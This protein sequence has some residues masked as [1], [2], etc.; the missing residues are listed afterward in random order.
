MQILKNVIRDYVK[1]HILLLLA[2]LLLSMAI[3]VLSS[4]LP[5]VLGVLVNVITQEI[6]TS[7]EIKVTPTFIILVYILSSIGIAIA[8]YVYQLMFLDRLP[9]SVND[10]SRTNSASNNAILES[11]REAPYVQEIA[12]QRPDFC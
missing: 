1:K 3:S 2:F 9:S 6:S 12:V 5:S 7:E 10:L 8:K 11:G 4:L